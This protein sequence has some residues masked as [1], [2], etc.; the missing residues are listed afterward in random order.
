MALILITRPSS[1]LQFLIEIALIHVGTAGLIGGSIL[2]KN[3]RG[4]IFF[5]YPVA[6]AVFFHATYNLLSL[7]R[8]SFENYLI[9][10]LLGLLIVINVI[11]F[12]RLERFIHKRS[13]D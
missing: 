9:F 12:L 13:L 1:A 7:E 10:F 11:N 2:L 8:N 5:V 6:I 3:V 4:I